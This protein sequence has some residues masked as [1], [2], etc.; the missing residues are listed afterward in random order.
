[1]CVVG[2]WCCCSPVPDRLVHE[3]MLGPGCH[4]NSLTRLRSKSKEERVFSVS[5]EL[6]VLRR[7]HKQ[8][9]Q[10]M[11]G[12]IRKNLKNKVSITAFSLMFMFDDMFTVKS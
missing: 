7:T 11:Q 9:S 3:A 5:N 10:R 1:M 8:E 4:G 12:V 6:F 2:C